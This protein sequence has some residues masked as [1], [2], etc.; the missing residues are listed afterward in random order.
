VYEKRKDVSVKYLSAIIICVGLWSLANYRADI[1]LTKQSI[2]FWSGIAVISVLFFTTFFTFFVEQYIN[3]KVSTYKGII[4]TA[5]AVVLSLFAF[6]K[7]STVDVTVNYVSPSEITIGPLYNIISIFFY[8]SFVYGYFKLIKQFKVS[9]PRQK[10]QIKYFLIGIS[11][12]VISVSIFNYILPLLGETR[13]YSIGPVS[14]I[15]MIIFTCYA[16][17]KHKLFDT[18]LVIRTLEKAVEK[19]TREIS[20]LQKQQRQMMVNIAHN[21]QNPLTVIKGELE[22]IFKDKKDNRVENINKSI[23]DLSNYIYE[24]LRISSLETKPQTIYVIHN[25][26]EILESVSETFS[27]LAKTKNIQ[28][29]YYIQKNIYVLCNDKHIEE[30]LNNLL[31]NA[32]KYRKRK[33]DKISV[34]LERKKNEAIITVSDNGLGINPEDLPHIFKKFYRS[35]DIKYSLKG[36]GLGLSIAKQIVENHGGK[37]EVKSKKSLGSVFSVHLPTD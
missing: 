13:F 31:S 9:K 33:N 24:I 15:F 36:T 4:F 14:T 20:D 32:L 6:S 1:S 26:S 10:Q 25:L 28:F 12:T 27:I 29:E 19:R 16:I 5:P 8:S 23:N 30:M 35:K 18:K 21:I 22:L 17:L 34:N 37:I 11:F 7:W 2:I 3:K